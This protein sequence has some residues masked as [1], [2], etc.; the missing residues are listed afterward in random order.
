MGNDRAH[1]RLSARFIPDFQISLHRCASCS[2]PAEKQIV[3]MEQKLLL[4]LD[5]QKY[6][7]FFSR[8]DLQMTNIVVSKMT[9]SVSV[10]MT[11]D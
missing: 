4:T 6:T 3:E 9:N 11:E 8:C 7:P 2:A 10:R 1:I 5:Y